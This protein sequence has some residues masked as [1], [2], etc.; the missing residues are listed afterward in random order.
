MTAQP[1]SWKV[2]TG[3]PLILVNP[4]SASLRNDLGYDFFNRCEFC[5]RCTLHVVCIIFRS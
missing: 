5:C 4:A 2:R 3:S 1:S